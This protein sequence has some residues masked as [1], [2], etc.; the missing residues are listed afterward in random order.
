MAYGINAAAARLRRLV[1]KAG[2]VVPPPAK[3][4]AALVL[5]IENAEMLRASLGPRALDRLVEALAL[6][7]TAELCFVPQARFPGQT[8][9]YGLLAVRRSSALPGHLAQLGAICRSP[10]DLGE[11]RVTPVV[12]AVIVSDD[13]G[14]AGQAALYAFGRDALD[15]CSPLTQGGQ[16]RFVE[17]S[18]EEPP[19]RAEPLFSPDQVQCRFQPQ[20]CCDTGRVVGLSVL[21][22]IEHPELGPLDLADFQTRLSDEVLGAAQRAVLRQALSALRGWDRM[23]LQV[24]V[25]TLPLGDR[26]LADPA[27]TEAVLWELDRLE[28]EPARLEIEVTEPIGRSGGRA[29]VVENLQRLCSNGCR[30]AI[31]D[32]GS[33]QAGLDDIRLLRVSRVRVGHG[34][35]AGCDRR[36]DQQRMIL[37]I[38]ALAEH[39]RLATLADG[40]AT[41]D[42]KSFLSQIGFG[43]IQGRAVVPPQTAREMDEVLTAL[44]TSLPPQF[45]LS[46]RA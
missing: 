3:T 44:E 43:A 5:R 16:L 42:E 6:R 2:G 25:V 26:V 21:A 46:R 33:G 7:L 4:R 13:G 27:F 29:P 18:R 45:G 28:L 32:F 15:A 37:A 22:G 8:E 41:I 38:L 9:L 20:I 19:L 12:N 10:V 35:T 23:G 39:L 40:V 36:V 30:I 11:I 34:F 17:Y 24:P 1:G 31:G 14:R